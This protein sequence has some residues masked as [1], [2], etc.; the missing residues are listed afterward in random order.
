VRGVVVK[1][2]GQHITATYSE[3]L[4]APIHTILIADGILSRSP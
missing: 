3:T 1:R 4:A 2:D